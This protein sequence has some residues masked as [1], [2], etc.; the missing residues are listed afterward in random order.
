M[1]KK[2]KSLFIVE[3]ETSKK[4][5]DGT[6]PA[7]TTSTKPSSAK[8]NPSKTEAIKGK[9]E[10]RFVNILLEAIEKNNIDGFD[11]LE[12]KQSLQ[13]LAEMNMDETTRYKSAF[14]MAA[15][16]GLNKQKLV[17]SVKRYIQVLHDEE[18][19][20]NEALENQKNQRI[21]KR[22]SNLKALKDGIAEKEKQIEKLKKQI[23]ESRAKLASMNNEIAAA[24]AKMEGTKANFYASYQAVLSQ[25][26]S[27]LKKVTDYL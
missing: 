7:K 26:E 23:E 10:D 21:N 19:K 14:A 5:E 1:L 27:D 6:T 4:K 17:S 24:E 3:D 15:T 9:P 13:S 16:M 2:L 12:Y 18:G 25:M 8:K 20:F 22:H 11:Y